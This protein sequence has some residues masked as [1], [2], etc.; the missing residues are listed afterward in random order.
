MIAQYQQHSDRFILFCSVAGCPV[1]CCVRP[2][3]AGSCRRMVVFG[4][5]GVA[6]N[7]YSDLHVFDTGEHGV[8]LR[9]VVPRNCLLENQLIA[10]YLSDM[11][12]RTH[13]TRGNT[14]HMTG[15]VSGD[16][17]EP[18]ISGFKPFPRGCH[19]A[20]V[21]QVMVANSITHKSLLT[22]RAV[23]KGSPRP[24]APVCRSSICAYHRQ[25]THA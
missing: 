6:N 12:Q 5:R 23:L 17:M 18:T 10:R 15:T 1:P 14:L 7:H 3:S 25:H 11:M 16:W 19:A 20:T 13:K 22:S 24:V 21:A 2:S 9:T 8:Q 4:G